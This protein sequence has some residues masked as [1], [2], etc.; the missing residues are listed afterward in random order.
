MKIAIIYPSLRAVGGAENVAVWLAESL[1]QKGHDVVVFTREFAEEAWGKR[2]DRPYRVHLLEFRKYRST[3]KT[4]RG[5]GAA[6]AGA[7]SAYRFDV[8]NPHNY[9]A[10]LWVYYA[11]QQAAVFPPVLLYL[12]EP[13]RTFYETITDRHVLRLPGIKNLW[14]R[15][16]PKR[17]LRRLR[18][19]LYGYRRLDKASVLAC[20]AVLAN[21]NYTAAVAR[22]IYDRDIHACPLGISEQRFQAVRQGAGNT[23][24]G[25]SAPP[26]SLTVARIERAKNLETLLKAFGVLKREGNL[27]EGFEHRIAGKGPQLEQLRAQ[28]R[29]MGLDGTVRFLGFVSDEDMAAHY[30]G[31]QFLVHIPLDE[32][33]GLVPL[34][35]ALLKKPSIVSDHGG[36]A[37]NVLDGVTGLHVDALDPQD[38][39]AKIEDCLNNPAMAIRMGSEAYSWVMKNKTW[40]MFVKKFEEQLHHSRGRYQEKKLLSKGYRV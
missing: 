26:F 36:P 1:A 28:C 31:A 10:N 5:A 9:P 16:R 13:P 23:G 15:Y 35:A 14:N 7:L 30:G 37:E 27:P 8:L 2:A 33:F 17:L 34:E 32:P 39:A 24:V 29:R 11:R 40:A 38:I 21:S 6:L 12:Q 19:A 3:L 22:Q 18:Q 4:N 25:R 20:D